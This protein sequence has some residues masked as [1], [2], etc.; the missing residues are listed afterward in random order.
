MDILSVK[1]LSNNKTVQY[2]TDELVRYLIHMGNNAMKSSGQGDV[3][4]GTYQALE[5]ET[6]IIN[7]LDDEIYI[8]INKQ[9]GMI[10]GPNP[11]SVLL[12]VYRYLTEC[13]CAFLSPSSL[14]EAIPI[15]T[16]PQDCQIQETPSYRYRGISMEGS[17]SLENLL[18]FIDWLPKVGM[19][20]YHSQLKDGYTFFDRW[21]SH[22]YNSHK[23]AEFLDHDTATKFM[24]KAANEIEKRGLIY[25]TM[26]HGLTCEPFDIKGLGW[27]KVEE[28]PPK[29]ITPLLAKV[30]GKR[31]FWRGIPVNTNACYSNPK[32]RNRIITYIVNYCMD[33]PDVDLFHFWLADDLNNHCEC[34]ECVKR[35][36]SD[37][38]VLMLN[39]LDKALEKQEVDTKIVFLLFYELLWPPAI[40]K[41]QNQERFILLFAPLARKYNRPFEVN[42]DLSD[43]PE[44]TRNNIHLSSTTEED[45]S[46]LKEW[47][48]QFKGDS[49]IFIYHLMTTGW[50]KDIAGYQLS[51]VLHKDIRR[52][53]NFGLNGVSSCQTQRTFF[54]TGLPMN[55]L[56]RT[57]WNT[58]LSFS[59]ISSQYF[60]Q[61][62]G[63]EGEDVEAYIAKLS[64]MFNPDYLQMQV[65]RI[66]EKA[67]ETFLKVPEYIDSFLPVIK[68]NLTQP[69]GC[70]RMNWHL[71]NVFSS[72]MK[73]CAIMFH[74]IAIGNRAL[75]AREH[76]PNFLQNFFKYEDVLH[77]VFDIEWFAR[78]FKIYQVDESH[79]TNYES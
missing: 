68:A 29:E 7:H 3:L 71:L 2:A 8:N 70:I 15:N 61:A 11:R 37:W 46:Y 34:A 23:E 6:S 24:E 65:P 40:E 41:I 55:V 77:N 43:L 76:W 38:Y 16:K 42:Y 39:E 54:P 78:N 75:V 27:D 51:E 31:A 69:N 66:D 25:Q 64:H 21:Y 47:R 67:A 79:F 62:Y 12:S 72:L 60:R 56:A 22:K 74:Q 49:F 48:D 26:G 19:N 59:D 36:P 52:Y 53:Q 18:S 28:D 58:D 35:I 13:G 14:G 33:N 9:K 17:M 1:P 50:E 5:I 30:N 32:A 63:T 44:F 45:F 73:E 20:S 4:I 57:M 10:S